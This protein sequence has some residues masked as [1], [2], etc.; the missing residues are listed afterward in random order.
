M[1]P[2]QRPLPIIAAH[3]LRTRREPFDGEDWLFEMKYDGFRGL[4]YLEGGRGRLISRNKREM[5]RFQP[6]ADALAAAL[7]VRTAIIDGEIIVKDA[8]GRPIFLDMLRRPERASYVAFDLLWL[9]GRDLRAL[10]L[11]ERKRAL[12]RLL[13]KPCRG[14]RRVIEEALCVEREGRRLFAL[15][16]EHDL[17]GIVAKRAAG[18]YAASSPWLRIKNRRYS[19]AAARGDLFL[20]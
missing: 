17:E 4:L 12:R 1:S 9:N 6:L 16:L 14:R 11:L 18:T 5:R 3:P 15:V 19:Q 10:P 2:A 20:K 8:A 7:R 13:P